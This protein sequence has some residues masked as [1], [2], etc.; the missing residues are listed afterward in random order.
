MKKVD[1]NGIEV[2][3]K[4]KAKY[5]KWQDRIMELKGRKWLTYSS[6]CHIVAREFRESYANILRKTI[7]WDRLKK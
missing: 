3:P 5:Q 4:T 1:W 7:H 2:T 6:A